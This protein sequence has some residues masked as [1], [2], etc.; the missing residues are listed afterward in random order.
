M[1]RYWTAGE[2][3][4]KTLLAMIDGFPAGLAIDEEPINRELARRQ[5]GYGRGGRQ[6]IETDKV[7]VMTGIWKGLTL[8]SP[9]ALQVI[10]RDYKLERLEDLPRPRPGHGD[11]TGAIKFLGPIRAILERASARETAVRVAAGALAKQLL[12]EFGIQVYGFVDELGGIAID[13]PEN[14]DDVDAMI[15]KR[16]ESIIYSLNPAQD[17]Q[18]KELI[19]KTG[20]AGDTLGGIVEVRVVGAPFG[21]GTHAQWE[22]K[23]DGKLA[24]AVMAVQA[25]KGVEIGMGFE[26]ARLPGSQVHDPIHYDATQL[27]S[28]NLGYTRPTNNAGGLEAGMTNGQTIVVRAAK[29]PI[30]TL[31]KP[32]ESVN[33]ETKESATASYE[34][35]DVCAVSAASVIV[36]SVV[37]FEIATAL[38]DKFGGDSLEEMKA[39]YQLFM[40]MARKR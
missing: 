13:R 3:H 19:D 6:R 14:V 15:A 11:L 9:I 10:N 32:L 36:E 26:A 16:D 30:S 33:L 5:G 35:S 1:L 25:I 39:R 8:G 17:P 20:K 21:L 12:A 18:F 7:E 37:A 29:K 23:L 38:V 2:S 31:A 40:N 28:T 24:Q 34:R 22:R 27:E 4:G